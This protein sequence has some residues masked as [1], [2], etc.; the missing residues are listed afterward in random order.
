MMMIMTLLIGFIFSVAAGIA[1]ILTGYLWVIPVFFSGL[2]TKVVL[3]LGVALAS[4][5][6]GVLG[7]RFGQ[8]RLSVLGQISVS[9]FLAVLGGVLV[10]WG[11]LFVI[12]NTRGV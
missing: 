7:F 6:S 11:S 3:W 4:F 2:K 12:V 9:V 5:V 8:G 1:I 10:L